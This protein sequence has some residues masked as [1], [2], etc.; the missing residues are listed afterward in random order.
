MFQRQIAHHFNTVIAT[1]SIM[2][3]QDDA[4]TATAALNSDVMV[5]ISNLKLNQ[6][7]TSNATT[8]EE[9]SNASSSKANRT[10]ENLFESASCSSSSPGNES[11]VPT[12]N[13][14]STSAST[15]N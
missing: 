14:H 2:N 3:D 4:G 10:N 9:E 11:P 6:P 12:S 13:D 8:A 5:E 15:E 7:S 1:S